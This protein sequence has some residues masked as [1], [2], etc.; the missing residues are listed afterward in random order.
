MEKILIV[1][2]FYKRTDEFLAQELQ[3]TKSQALHLIKE[4]L[5]ICEGKEVKKGGHLLKEG[6]QVII[7]APKK[8]LV[9]QD[10]KK[11]LQVEIGVIYEDEDLLVLNKPS[12][13]VVH[14]AL[15]VKEPTLVDWLEEQNY[16]LSNLS[17]KERYGIVHR[18]DKD[19]SGALVVAKN[20]YSHA[21]LSEQLKS[22][23]MGRYY[24]A[25]L[26]SSL[27]PKNLERILVECHLARNPNNRLKMVATEGFRQQLVG[28]Y[29]KSEFMSLIAQKNFDLIV[30]KLYTGRTHQIR[31]HLERINKHIIG[32]SVYGLNQ[33]LDK[34]QEA[35]RIM[36]HAY[37]IEF[38][39]PRSKEN[40][41]FKVPLLKDMLEYLKNIFDEV[42]LNE[43]L[44]ENKILSA[45]CAN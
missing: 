44:D 26:N 10:V 35:R 18:L 9:S 19:T 25:L 40:M 32:D 21:K 12:N 13:L 20:N 8:P 31:A 24:V 29:S 1:P 37:L 23:I 5:V 2:A 33:K 16:Q 4:S 34:E 27:S 7:K 15:S 39:H 3:I 11:E 22:K 17:G 36:L 14:R 6:Y 28:R 45:F 41:R 42:S 38:E 30:A 43:V